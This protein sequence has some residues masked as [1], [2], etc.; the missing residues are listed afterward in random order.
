MNDELQAIF[1]ETISKINAER[2][3]FYEEINKAKI[4]FANEKDEFRDLKDSTIESAKKE[5]I[6]KLYPAMDKYITTKYTSKQNKRKIYAFIN[7][8]KETFTV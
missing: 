6:E 8:F 7:A 3:K 4:L 5:V 2:N 1:D